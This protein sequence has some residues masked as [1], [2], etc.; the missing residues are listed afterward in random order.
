MWVASVIGRVW[1]LLTC[2]GTDGPYGK[3]VRYQDFHPLSFSEIP[4]EQKSEY[5]A[6]EVP[7][8]TYWT[9]HGYIVVRIDERGIGSS[10]GFLDTMSDQTSSDFAECIEWAAEQS[11][12]NGRIGLLGIS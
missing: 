12:S 9:K 5:S 10:P 4:D 1:R 6:W 8:P 7:E 11:W 2:P 3:D